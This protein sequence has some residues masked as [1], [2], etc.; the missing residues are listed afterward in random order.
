MSPILC[1]FF[2][3]FK[4]KTSYEMRISDWSSDVCSSDLVPGDAAGVARYGYDTLPNAEV[5]PIVALDFRAVRRGLKSLHALLKARHRIVMA[6]PVHFETLAAPKSRDRY[7]RLLRSVP[8]G[9]R[10]FLLFELCCLPQGVAHLRVATLADGLL[11]FCHSLRNGS[12]L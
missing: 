9:M 8:P 6:V 7:L 5:Y 2:C 12:V 11:P 10:N 1:I 4:Q 3:F